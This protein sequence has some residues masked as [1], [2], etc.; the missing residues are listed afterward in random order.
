M[1]DIFDKFDKMVDTTALAKDA[2][3]A[4]N[5]AH[6]DYEKVPH[7]EYEVSINRMEIKESKKGDPMLSIWFKVLNGKYENSLIFMN[8]V[9]T[10]GFQVHL[11]NQILSALANGTVP[12]EFT[13]YKQ[14]NDVVCDVHEFAD[15][16]EYLLEYGENKKHY[17]TFKIKEVYDPEPLD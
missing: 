4:M 7:G 6:G 12:V 15:K 17:D 9:I 16:H 3:E 11:A 1:T 5:D 2:K 8:Q 10:Q 13:T 14:Y